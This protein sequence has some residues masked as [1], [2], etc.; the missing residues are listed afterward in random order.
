MPYAQIG[1]HLFKVHR[2][3]GLILDDQ[4]TFPVERHVEAVPGVVSSYRQPRS[5]REARDVIAR[6]NRKR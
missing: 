2:E 3:E 6:G 4:N 1:E 5:D